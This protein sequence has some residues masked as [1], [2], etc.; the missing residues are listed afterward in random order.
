M[1]RPTLTDKSLQFLGDWR[2]TH[3]TRPAIAVFDVDWTL[4]VIAEEVEASPRRALAAKPQI[5]AARELLGELAKRGVLIVWVTARADLPEVREFTRA[6]LA[7]LGLP[8]PFRVALCPERLRVA[9][10]LIADF[11]Y[12]AR[13]AVERDAGGT[14]LF[15]V[16]DQ[17]GD[18]RRDACPPATGSRSWLK[19]REGALMIPGR[20]E[21]D[22]VLVKLNV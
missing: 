8:D 5:L 1:L 14:V 16:G 3:P 4:A 7:A 21:G 2:S 13:R 6:Q 9:P 15:A 20:R 10:E 11:K 17:W 22:V 19:T 12:R 18:L